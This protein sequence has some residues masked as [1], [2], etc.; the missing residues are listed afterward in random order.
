MTALLV[1]TSI[2]LQGCAAGP[3]RLH[4]LWQHDEGLSY[5][6]DKASAVEYP[7]DVAS[8]RGPQDPDLFTAPRNIRSLE[9]V[10]PREVSL[11]ECIRLALAETTVIRDDGSFNSPGNPILSRPAQVA[12]VLDPAPSL[13][14]IVIFTSRLMWTVPIYG[15]DNV[16]PVIVLLCFMF[17]MFVILLCVLV[18]L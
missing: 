8:E 13:C 6:V 1:L 18:L 4:Y 11:N 5:Y 2:L 7:V 15:S 9:E 3:F 16:I 12:S 17:S 10:D 14:K